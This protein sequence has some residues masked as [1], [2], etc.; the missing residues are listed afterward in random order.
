MK[1]SLSSALVL[2]SLAI[3]SVL[4]A[5]L[6]SEEPP[7]PPL[8]ARP[9]VD[10]TLKWNTFAGSTSTDQPPA[11]TVDASGNIY[12]VSGGYNWGSPIRPWSGNRDGFVVKFNA[13]GVL[14]WNT[15]LGGAQDDNAKAIFLD[16]NGNIYVTG[17]SSGTWGSPVL[18]YSALGDAFVAKLDPSGALLWNTFLGGALGTDTGSGVAADAAGNVYVA[19][20]SEGTWG[21]PL[22]PYGGGRDVFAAKLNSSGAVVWSTF[23]GSSVQEYPS[24][25]GLD[26][27][28]YIYIGGYGYGTWGTPINPYNS[29]A[30]IFVVKMNSSGSVVWNTFLGGTGNDSVD[31]ATVDSSGNTYIV[32]LS[33]ATWGSPVD[34]FPA[35][36]FAVGA[37][38]VDSSGNLV[39]NTFMGGATPTGNGGH[40]IVPDSAGNVYVAG[41]STAN[42]GSPLIPY[43]G[44]SDAFVAKLG[45]NGARAW[46]AFLGSTAGN[47]RGR[48]VVCD[49][50]GN[51][52]VA[53][54]SNATWGSPLRPFAGTN[55]DD[56]FVAKL[57][58]DAIWR[59]RHAVGDFDGDGADE[60]AVD[61]GASGIWEYDGGA[62]AQISTANPKSLLAAD[63]DGDGADELLADLGSTGLWLWNAGAWNQLSGVNVEGL[64]AGDVDADGAAEVVGDFGTV[65]LWLFNGG[66]WTQLSGVNADFVL[67]ANLDDVGG[68]EIIGDFGAVGL[69]VWSGGAW[70]QLSGVNA[71]Y[72]ASGKWAGGRFLIGDFGATG[73]WQCKDGLW[74][75]WSS[76]NADYMI[77]ADIDNDGEDEVVGDFG[78]VG[79]W[80]INSGAWTELSGLDAE[81]M[82]SADVNADNKAEIAVDFGSIGLWLWNSAGGWT[83]LSGVN[84]DYVFAG[85]FDKDNKDEIMA[86]FGALGLWLYDQGVWTQVSGSNPE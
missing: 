67:V 41:E 84:A 20:W 45:K 17:D 5:P 18:P 36:N 79:L 22:N 78:T 35:T 53:G 28:G 58:E 4:P 86:D 2:L 70:Y 14:Q 31:N 66:A 24:G 49:G 6:N 54:L 32:G 21:S 68:A 81:F 82:V 69:W 23:M 3:L 50:S 11:V 19:G 38:K 42:W 85:D 33:T 76:V 75:Q 83:Q 13:N 7:A 74:T 26:G 57:S 56:P 63:V 10:V 8:N 34:T 52:I 44:G 51:V 60:A 62:W 72:V 27:S 12:M 1:R 64:A 65:G 40:G 71:D 73:L 59:P 47:D 43:L 48:A 46:N 80:L 37:T 29:G 9:P 15:F 39:W 25:I 16:A 55:T 77:A 30:D 61:F